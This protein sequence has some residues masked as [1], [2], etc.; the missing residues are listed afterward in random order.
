MVG[1]VS[2]TRVIC[3]CSSGFAYF[4]VFRKRV[5]TFLPQ[6]HS[7]GHRTATFKT[8]HAFSSL[9][10]TLTT[11]FNVFTTP[12]SPSPLSTARCEGLPS[13]SHPEAIDKQPN[14]SARYW[15]HETFNQPRTD[16]PSFVFGFLNFINSETDCRPRIE[17][18]V[19]TNTFEVKY[20]TL[21]GEPQVRRKKDTKSRTIIA[22][23]SEASN[24][25]RKKFEERSLSN[26]VKKD[27]YEPATAGG[28]MMVSHKLFRY[29]SGSR[30]GDGLIVHT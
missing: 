5:S 26:N 9:L 30:E 24:L 21:N 6:I 14:L 17:A 4:Y 12:S 19:T 23:K 29:F 28:K 1:W 7:D 11:L 27:R 2:K 15:V 8:C 25:Y 20:L 10:L 13:Q 18:E 3:P 16:A 22:S